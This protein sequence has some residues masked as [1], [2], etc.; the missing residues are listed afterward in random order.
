MH[1]DLAQLLSCFTQYFVTW[2]STLLPPSPR[3]PAKSEIIAIPLS[4]LATHRPEELSVLTCLPRPSC[5]PTYRVWKSFQGLRTLSV[6]ANS[7]EQH[8]EFCSP[9]CSYR[10]RSSKHVSIKGHS[11][12]TPIKTTFLLAAC[13]L[14]LVQLAPI[15][16]HF[17]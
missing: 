16:L 6:L 1:T 12:I 8:V 2:T 3:Q 15:E 13:F 11:V 17:T 10:I 4:F 9:K 14:T 7:E 5:T